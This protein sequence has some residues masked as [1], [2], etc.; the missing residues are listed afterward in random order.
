M[1]IWQSFHLRLLAV[2]IENERLNR[3]LLQFNVDT[4]PEISLSFVF[5]SHSTVYFCRI[6][7]FLDFLLLI[8]IYFAYPKNLCDFRRGR[9]EKLSLYI[10]C[11]Y[12]TAT[13]NQTTSIKLQIQNLYAQKLMFESDAI[14]FSR[15]KRS[16]SIH[17]WYSTSHNDEIIPVILIYILRKFNLFHP[18]SPAGCFSLLNNGFPTFFGFFHFSNFLSFQCVR[19]RFLLNVFIQK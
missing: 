3:I 7:F 19:I 4:N 18:F 11:I 2:S 15:R 12:P 16:S 8:K 14:R 6:I 10:R 17:F 13:L 5:R 1:I 9:F